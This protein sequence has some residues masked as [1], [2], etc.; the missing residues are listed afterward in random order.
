MRSIHDVALLLRGSVP[1]CGAALSIHR[2]SFMQS[3]PRGSHVG[4]GLGTLRTAPGRGADFM[5]IHSCFCCLRASVSPNVRVGQHR[6]GADPPADPGMAAPHTAFS[7]RLM[8][9]RP[10]SPGMPGSVGSKRLHPQCLFSHGLDPLQPWPGGPR[11]TVWLVG[12]I[13]FFEMSGLSLGS[14]PAHPSLDI[15]LAQVINL[16]CFLACKTRITAATS[17]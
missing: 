8:P 4:L 15:Y 17:R 16:A 9:M 14:A 6:A 5:G 2:A 11:H 13:V 7:W 10:R 1:A 12:K 3:S